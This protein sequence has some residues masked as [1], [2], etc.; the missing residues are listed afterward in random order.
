MGVGDS[1]ANL[2]QIALGGGT[3]QAFLV[4]V[5]D[6]LKTQSELSAAIGTIRVSALSCDYRI[7]KAPDGQTFDARKV[8]VQYTPRSGAAKVLDYNQAC[9]AGTG[10]R[11]DDANR[12]T[13][14][15]ACD[16]TCDTIKNNGSKVDIVFGCATQVVA[17]K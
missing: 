17:V 5:G 8:N 4:S 7:P 10:W 9:A 16:A 13:R 3:K 2:N 14:V 15:I 1:L 12:P 6:P 11:Y